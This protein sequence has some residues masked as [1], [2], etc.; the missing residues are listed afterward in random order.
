MIQFSSPSKNQLNNISFV[1]LLFGGCFLVCLFVC[2]VS[3]CG[4]CEPRSHCVA[5]AGLVLPM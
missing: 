2:L 1:D 5:L 3:C 4:L